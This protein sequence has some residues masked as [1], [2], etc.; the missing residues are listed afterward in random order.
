L[1][2]AACVVPSSPIFVTLMKEAPGSS[3][4]S[5][6]TRAT[7]RNIPED[8]IILLIPWFCLFSHVDS[9]LVILTEMQIFKKIIGSVY[10]LLH[11]VISTLIFVWTMKY[12]SKILFSHQS[13]HLAARKIYKDSSHLIEVAVHSVSLV[14]YLRLY[15]QRLSSIGIIIVEE[16]FELVSILGALI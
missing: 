11:S 14:V 10:G 4:I 12:C 15:S 3:E 16:F 9:N 7:R 13:P 8:A 2:V 6:F 1:L 5:V